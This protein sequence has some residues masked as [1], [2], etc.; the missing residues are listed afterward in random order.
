MTMIYNRTNLFCLLTVFFTPL[1]VNGKTAQ[2]IT[3][4]EDAAGT[5][6]GNLAQDLKID[7]ADDPHTSF[8]FMQQPSSSLIRMRETDGLLTIG[9]RIDREHICGQS[10]ECLITFDVVTFSKEKFQLIHVEVEVKDI[11]DNSPQFPHNES[12]IE[13]S[14]SAAVGTRFPLD[15]A[16]D[17]D[18][19]PNY[20]ENYY[21]SFNS[22]FGIEVRSREDGTFCS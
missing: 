1:A 18:V 13:M 9:E 8:R 11:N 17:Q 15:I 2:Y 6:I 5:E 20:I 21:I 16:V 14:E 12:Y 19:G 10:P 22:H 4:E 3:Y 7:P